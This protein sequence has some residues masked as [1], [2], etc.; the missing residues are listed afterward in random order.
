MTDTS[1]SSGGSSG[2]KVTPQM[3]S[4]AAASCDSTAGDVNDRL[5]GLKSY[6]ATMEGIWHGVAQDTF[7]AL[8]QEWDGLARMLH[9]ALTDIASGLRG[10]YVNYTDTE[11]ANLKSVNAIRGSLGQA[12]LS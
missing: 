7:Q 10:N 1:G 8:M 9:D 2:F 3:I 6:V 4:D 12:N 11:Q 5:A